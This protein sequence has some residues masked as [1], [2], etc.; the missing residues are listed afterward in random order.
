M[1]VDV[2]RVPGGASLT[3]APRWTCHEL[4]DGSIREPCIRRVD[5][6]CGS[7]GVH[8]SLYGRVGHRAALHGGV[9]SE[10][11]ALRAGKIVRSGNHGQRSR[12]NASNNRRRRHGGILAYCG[13]APAGLPG[14]FGR[15][16]G[17]GG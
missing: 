2:S 9:D 13:E 15:H 17:L 5:D 12:V 16:D 14:Q 6:V 11:V 3:T 1:G 10:R 4:G 8:L 7:A